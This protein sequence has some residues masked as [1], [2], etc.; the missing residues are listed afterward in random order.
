VDDRLCLLVSIVAPPI[1]SPPLDSQTPTAGALTQAQNN[2]G[3]VFPDG[4][5]EL[6]PMKPYRKD[7]FGKL[8]PPRQPADYFFR[9]IFFKAPVDAEA[10]DEYA[11]WFGTNSDETFARH[12]MAAA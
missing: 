8:P 10:V 7:D 9:Y 4:V 1:D 11:H 5:D 6:A 12:L 2:F 3:I